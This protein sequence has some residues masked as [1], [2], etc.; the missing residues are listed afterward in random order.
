MLPPCGSMQRCKLNT[1]S[2]LPKRRRK[3][4]APLF[5]GMGYCANHLSQRRTSNVRDL[6][7][8]ALCF[9]CSTSA[10]KYMSDFC[11]LW[12]NTPKMPEM[13]S[14]TFLV[15]RQKA[16]YVILMGHVRF[17]MRFN[18]CTSL[19]SLQHKVIPKSLYLKLTALSL[20]PPS[21]IAL[22]GPKCPVPKCEFPR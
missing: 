9:A 20:L 3:E 14:W 10:M 12:L 19:G 7:R 4:L 8:I 1:R 5:Q 15:F 16:M 22:A 21:E 6:C 17:L 11:L 2:R 18:T 13:S